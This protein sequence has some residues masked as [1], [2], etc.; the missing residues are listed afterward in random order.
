[1]TRAEIRAEVE[2]RGYDYVADARLNLWIR[3]GY[4]YVC[5]LE[6]WWFLEQTTSGPAPLTIADLSQVLHVSYGDE[7]LRG[8]DYRDIRDMDPALDDTGTPVMWYLDGETIHAWPTSSEEISVRYI[9]KPGAL[10]ADQDEPL[11]P[12]AHHSV[13]VDLAENPRLKHKHQNDQ[14]RG[15]QMVVD[16]RIQDQRDHKMVRNYQ[17][18]TQIVQT[19]HPDD[20]IA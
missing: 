3:Q 7:V 19:R 8:T 18:P 2:N 16:R 20:Y 14:A 11:I 4:E 15:R 6:P 5:S 12:E 13:L 9:R 1:M 10:A 17:N